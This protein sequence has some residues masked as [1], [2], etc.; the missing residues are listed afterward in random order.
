MS[1]ERDHWQLYYGKQ[2]DEKLIFV[3]PGTGGSSGSLTPDDFVNLLTQVNH[4]SIHK[5]RFVLTYS[6]DEIV[7]AQAILISL[8]KLISNVEM[9]TPLKI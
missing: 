8:H 2:A 9:A 3:H 6:G 5:C 1:A 4:A 7:L